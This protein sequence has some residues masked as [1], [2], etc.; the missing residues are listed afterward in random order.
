MKKIILILAYIMLGSVSGNAFII[1][2]PG[3]Y[4]GIQLAINAASGG[5]T[6]VVEPGTYF[7][8]INFR[9][10][11]IV[12]TSKFYLDDDYSFISSTIINGST[13][14]HPDTA[15]CVII[16][17]GEDSTA[18]LQGFTLT[19]GTGTAWQDI[20]GAGRYREGG[21]ILIELSSPTIRHNV[22]VDNEAIN[23][24]GLV[25]AGGGGIRIGDGNPR[26]LNNII[27]SNQGKYGPGIVLNYTGA[28]VKNNVIAFNFGATSFNGGAGLW[29]LSNLGTTPKIIENNTIIYNSSAAG[30]GGVM[31]WATTAIL[32]NNIIWGNS[33]PTN[34]QILTVGGGNADASYCDIQGGYAGTGNIDQQPLYDSTNYYLSTSSPCID[35]GD[36]DTQYNDPE[37]SN[38]PGSAEF[39]AHGTLRNDIGAYGGPGSEIIAN[40]VVFINNNGIQNVP[41][42]FFLGQNYPNPFNPSTRINYSLFKQAKVSI[43]VYDNAGR[44]VSTLINGVQSAG[45]YDITFNS[46]GLA[47]GVY[48]YTLE[49]GDRRETRKMILLK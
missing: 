48:Y 12:I 14:S 37:D 8:N 41:E 4:S 40:T 35:M 32:R 36:P 39:P 45:E 28:I 20:H 7:E 27:K 19:G 17:S 26:I 44:E 46:A 49:A 31:I 47:G 24:A 30:T 22:I 18:V 13:P 16:S 6:I 38:N 1:N 3:D 21:G 2:V 11:N 42:D 5:D 15:S 29:I 9:G 10:K 34:S 33:S 25:S 43:K 23:S